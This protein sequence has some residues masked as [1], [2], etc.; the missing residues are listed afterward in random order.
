[1]CIKSK[2]IFYFLDE[3]NNYEIFKKKIDV[4]L[5]GKPFKANSIVILGT[6]YIFFE[7]INDDH[8]ILNMFIL[9]FKFRILQ[10][11]IPLNN[12]ELCDL[13]K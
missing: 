3:D 7:F 9:L 4:L 11:N 12:I 8:N 2:L 1:M 13:Y 5:D 6:K 10:L